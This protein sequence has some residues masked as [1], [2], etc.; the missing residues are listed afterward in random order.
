VQLKERELKDSDKK[1]LEEKVESI[2]RIKNR[3][4]EATSV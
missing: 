3:T 2:E 1:L 4:L